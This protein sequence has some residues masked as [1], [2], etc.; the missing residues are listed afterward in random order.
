MDG[1][2]TRNEDRGILRWGGLAGVAGGILFLVVFVIV[3]AFVP[4]YAADPAT[5]VQFFPEVGTVRIVENSLYLL[6]LILWVASVVAVERAAVISAVSARIG[7]AL[8]IAGI[9]LLAVGALPH[10][11]IA[12]LSAAY[13]APGAAAADQA[14]LALTWQAIQGMLDASLLAGLAVLSTGLVAL[15][16]AMAGAPA[17]GRRLGG[18]TVVMGAIGVAAS[19]VAM[20]DPGSP[21]PAL[22]MFALIAFH[23]VAGWRTL[24]LSRGGRTIMERTPDLGTA[25]SRRPVVERA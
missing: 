24:S 19:G 9:V 22:G 7:A 12:P 16:V 17:Y 14:T 13:H 4:A 6:V 25:S 11:A 15:G 1:L 3:G 20:V 21:A 23:L 18:F 10:V 5:A 8:G 2:M